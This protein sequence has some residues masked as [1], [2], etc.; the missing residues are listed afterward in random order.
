ME[1]AFGCRGRRVDETLEIIKALFAQ[2]LIEHQGEY[3]RFQPVQ[4]QPKLVQ[5]PWPPMLIVGDAPA[6]IKRAALLDDGCLP[7][8]QDFETP[9]ANMARIKEL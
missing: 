1:L 3:F 5:K 7:M 2:D 4:F 6:A 9:P 8:G